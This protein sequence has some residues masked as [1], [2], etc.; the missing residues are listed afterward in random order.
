VL[1][2]YGQGP[3]VPDDQALS[4]EDLLDYLARSDNHQHS[5]LEAVQVQLDA[6]GDPAEPTREQRAILEWLGSATLDWESTY[7]LAQPL[8]ETLLP[9][10]NLAAAFAL[11][12]SDFLKP[13]SHPLHQLLDQ[14]VASAIGWEAQL[15]RAGQALQQHIEHAVTEA[16]G[17]FSDRDT[18]L[19]AICEE[20]SRES[21][22]DRNRA[23]RM[24]QRGRRGPAGSGEDDQRLPGKI[25]CTGA[26]R[27]VFKRTMVCQCPTGD[28]EVRRKFTAVGQHE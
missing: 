7:P 1:E 5:P 6:I 11:T 12:D 3:S 2:R 4:L 24:A 8:A 26:H 19:A 23:R 15:G 16:L 14:I 20:F 22:R 10:K 28:S 13:G 25:S 18:D 21:E 27:R 17:W 9:I